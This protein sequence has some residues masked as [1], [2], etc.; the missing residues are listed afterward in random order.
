MKNDNITKEL[1]KAIISA[2]K[3]QTVRSYDFLDPSSVAE[4]IRNTESLFKERIRLM[5]SLKGDGFH[6]EAYDCTEDAV[7]RR[8]QA[9]VCK[10]PEFSRRFKAKYP[11]LCAADELLRL[12][13][14]TAALAYEELNR[15]AHAETAAALWILDYLTENDRLDDALPYLPESRRELDSVPFPNISD[16]VHNDDIIKGMLYVIRS[17]NQN[18]TAF[19]EVMR[20][21]EPEI[22]GDIDEMY[23]SAMMKVC[24]SLMGILSA[25]Q[26]EIHSLAIAKER[27]AKA[28]LESGASNADETLRRIRKS[29]EKLSVLHFEKDAFCLNALQYAKGQPE[30]E[31]SLPEKPLCI[32]TVNP[33]AYCFGYLHLLDADSDDIWLYN[34]SLYV[35]CSAC[36]CLPW[37]IADD[38]D[39]KAMQLDPA[40][41]DAALQNSENYIVPPSDSVLYKPIVT[42]PFLTQNSEKI[43]FSQ[44]IY[45]V[46]GL[47]PPRG[48]TGMSYMKA[49]FDAEELSRGEVD[50]LY[51]YLMLACAINRRDTNYVFIDED[52][53]APSEPAAEEENPAEST[54]L[55]A[56]R[57]ENKNLKG[58]INRLEHKLKE[59]A[60]ELQKAENDL[61]SAT[62]ELAELRSMIRKAEIAEEYTA[63]V[64]FPYTVQ[65]RTVVF[66]GHESWIK[67][68]KPLL[69]NVRFIDTP[70]RFDTSLLLNADAVWIQTNAISHSGFYRIIDIIRKHGIEL[71]YFNYSSAEKCAEQLATE[72][73]GEPV[74][75]E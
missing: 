63:T 36:A 42:P 50:L 49:L 30:S 62:G 40:F 3:E 19:D 29:D 65:K 32:D 57:Q 21:I 35:L 38:S 5:R 31:S 45:L 55:K 54:E 17:R 64:D 68:I 1:E 73:M 39:E 71:H 20:L 43:R 69:L 27:Q 24:D 37:A 46:S 33:Y 44:L 16:S 34:L 53:T 48:M 25:Y 52:E 75:S 56:L 60:A 51:D 41:L 12:N 28:A 47:V 61:I 14:P 22:V 10:A 58:L 72:D 18:R 26:K 9:I 4:L 23:L 59:S 70:T 67:A 13:A 15:T 7:K 2:K 11:N 74:Q 6:E 8:K 66:G